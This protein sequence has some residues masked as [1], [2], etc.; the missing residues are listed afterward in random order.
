VNA[1]ETRETV[2]R[3]SG[4]ARRAAIVQ[5]PLAWDWQWRKSE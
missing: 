4:I 3:E 5:A 1:A 2:Y